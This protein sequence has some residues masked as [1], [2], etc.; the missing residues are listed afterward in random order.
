MFLISAIRFLSRR[1]LSKNSTWITF[2]SW[3]LSLFSTS[4][5]ISWVNGIKLTQESWKLIHHNNQPNHRQYN[6]MSFLLDLLRPGDIFVD[7]GAHVGSYSI[8]ASW[9]RG[10][11]S[12]CFEP[13]A[14][15]LE[16]LQANIHLNH[17]ERLITVVPY[18]I[19]HREVAQQ[20]PQTNKTNNLSISVEYPQRHKESLYSLNHSIPVL[21]DVIRIGT[22]NAL[23]NLFQNAKESLASSSIKAV[24]LEQGV[25]TELQDLHTQ[26]QALQFEAYQYIP[27]QKRLLRL[28][29]LET[30]GNLYCR[31]MGWIEMRLDSADDQSFL[32]I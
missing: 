14:A 6:N 29:S 32:T 26:F 9:L 8:L 13:N 30:P 10:V 22:I 5:A 17:L 7:I 20:L 2:Q 15:V 28:N 27:D 16:Q 31:D 11:Y 12:Y 25:E 1:T 18:M 19:G 23:K 4:R 24:L 3:K 21:S